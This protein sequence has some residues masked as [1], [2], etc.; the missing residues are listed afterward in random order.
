V[1][2]GTE[3]RLAALALCAIGL[4]A[5]PA[6]GRAYDPFEDPPPHQDER[7]RLAFTGWGGEYTGVAGSGLGTGALLAG[8]L[9]WRLDGIEIGG[10]VEGAH[11]PE[12]RSGLSPV[13]LVRLT[14]RFETRRGLDATVTFG[15]GAGREDRWKAWYQVAVGARLDLGPLFLSGEVAFEQAD[16][17]RLAAGLGVRF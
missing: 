8:E 10:M 4:V 17:L 15:V 1:P 16:L 7:G 11:F 13:Y 9:S 2:A 6:A 12:Y 3:R 14:E 5:A